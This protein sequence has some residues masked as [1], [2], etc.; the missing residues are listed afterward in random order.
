MRKI[1]FVWIFFITVFNSYGQ[2][3][4]DTIE[5]TKNP[6]TVFRL[7]GMNLTPKQ[8]LDITQSNAEANEEMRIARNY[9]NAGLVFQFAGGFFIGWP[10]GTIIAGGN[11][12]WILAGIGAGLLVVSIPFTIAYTKHAKNAVILYNNGL[13]Q[14]VF[15]DMNVK[16][17]VTYNGIGLKITF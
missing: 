12:N 8:L 7:N 10:V 1:I 11:P 13:K 9:S 14:T 4:T 2:N 6:G 3:K 16:L 17:G 15:H 5:I